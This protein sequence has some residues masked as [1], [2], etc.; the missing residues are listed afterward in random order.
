MDSRDGGIRESYQDTCPDDDHN[1][2]L[3]DDKRGLIWYSRKGYSVKAYSVIIGTG[4]GRLNAMN[5]GVS[6]VQYAQ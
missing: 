5:A 6:C 4:K 3:S 1:C 2:R